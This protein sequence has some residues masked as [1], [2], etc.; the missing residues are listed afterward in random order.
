MS[1]LLAVSN[2]LNKLVRS[3]L[4]FA[5]VNLLQNHLDSLNERL[6]AQSKI[7]DHLASSVDRAKGKAD[8]L[9]EGQANGPFYRSVRLDRP[10]LSTVACF[11]KDSVERVCK[12][13]WLCYEPNKDRFF[14]F[15]DPH[16][17]EHNVPLNR[18]F[19]VDG[20]SIDHHNRFFMDYLDVDPRNVP[21]KEVRLVDKLTFILDR[22][23]SYNI[24]HTMHDDFFGLYVLHRLFAPPAPSD[25][26]PF[27]LDNWIM[28]A[29]SFEHLTYD[30]VHATLSLNPIQYRERVRT[31]TQDRTPLCFREAVLGNSKE[32]SWY[33]YGFIKPQGP[34]AD[35]TVSGLLIRDVAS[36]VMRRFG[37]REWDESV[38]KHT[39]QEMVRAIASRRASKNPYRALPFTVHDDLYIAIFSRRIDRL[40]LNEEELAER[41]G[42]IYGLP[43]KFVRMENMEMADQIAILRKSV[44][45]IGMHG[46]AMIL[47]IFLPPGALLVELYPLYVPAENYTPYRTMA[48]LQGMRMAYRAWVNTHPENTV[49]HPDKPPAGGGIAHL[50]P[51]EQQ[52]ILEAKTVPPHLCC[53]DPSWLYHIYQDTRVNITELV[54]LIDEGLKDGLK[55]LETDVVS[56]VTLRPGPVETVRCRT[57]ASPENPAEL[58]LHISWSQPWNGVRPSFYGIWMHQPYQEMFSNTTE[59]VVPSCERNSRLDLWVRPYI[60]IGAPG[61]EP[62]KGAYSEK[63]TCWCDPDRQAEKTGANDFGENDAKKEETS[64]SAS[65]E[66]AA[67]SASASDDK[68]EASHEMPASDAPAQDFSSQEKSDSDTI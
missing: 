60:R 39:M 40:I 65:A 66:S 28:F 25:D 55:Q 7:V 58:D 36:F 51:A 31:F 1:G 5:L 15:K 44:M 6:E 27:S 68:P 33:Q 41:L 22:F 49:A 38:I 8:Q 54:D 50:T 17:L 67:A 32:A 64:P 29:D 10:P 48:G 57:M 37:M 34:I 18:T 26:L 46:S 12:I 59:L 19:L 56:W 2:P 45:A 11:G 47:G 9:S 52:A 42:G 3:A 35:K 16:T 14:I 21:W 20:T 43:V 61:S 62:T 13:K 24:M 4:E 23:H 30:Y 63:Y 53:A